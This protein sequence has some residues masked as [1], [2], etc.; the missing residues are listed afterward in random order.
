[1]HHFQ[2]HTSSRKDQSATAISNHKTVNCFWKT[3]TSET[4]YGATVDSHLLLLDADHATSPSP[5]NAT[6]SDHRSTSQLWVILRSLPWER[7][8]QFWTTTNINASRRNRGDNKVESAYKDTTTTQG[9]WTLQWSTRTFRP[10]LLA[11]LF[12]T[13]R[14][15]QCRKRCPST[16]RMT[17]ET[18]ITTTITTKEEVTCQDNASLR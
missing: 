3:Q 10:R 11:F 2:C 5:T 9:P 17:I 16:I 18:T 8:T 4:D 12:K 13:P 1:M 15:R 14:F 6:S 7:F